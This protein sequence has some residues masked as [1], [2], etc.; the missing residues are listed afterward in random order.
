MA[1]PPSIIKSTMNAEER[2]FQTISLPFYQSYDLYTEEAVRS[3]KY[4]QILKFIEE[5]NKKGH[6]YILGNMP[7]T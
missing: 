3:R 6:S 7:Y 1:T 5:E 2:S 4:F